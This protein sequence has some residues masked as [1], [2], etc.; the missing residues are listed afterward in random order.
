MYGDIHRI[1]QLQVKAIRTVEFT[2][3]N[4]YIIDTYLSFDINWLWLEN[5]WLF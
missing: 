2:T 5:I 1:E 4:K 3:F